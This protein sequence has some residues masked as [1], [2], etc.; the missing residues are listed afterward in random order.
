MRSVISGWVNSGHGTC[1][2]FMPCNICGPCCHSTEM[3]E[4]G[5]KGS[6]RLESHCY[7]SGAPPPDWLWHVVHCFFANAFSPRPAL[8]CSAKTVVS[9]R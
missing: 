5:R 6:V 2:A 3:M 1:F 4:N 7:K 8:P 9:H